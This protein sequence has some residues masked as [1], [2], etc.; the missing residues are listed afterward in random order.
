MS[1]GKVWSLLSL[2]ETSSKKDE[3]KS[4][5][6]CSEELKV[7]TNGAEVHTGCVRRAPGVSSP[8]LSLSARHTPAPPPHTFAT[9]LTLR[10]FCR[11]KCSHHNHTLWD[12]S[13]FKARTFV[14]IRKTVLE[15]VI[16]PK[17]ETC[18]REELKGGFSSWLFYLKT[19]RYEKELSKFNDK[20]SFHTKSL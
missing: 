6:C 18:G 13:A 17:S 19:Q 12:K 9:W 20:A 15:S 3:A 14:V 4:Y 7:K 11:T 1:G 16:E 8:C 2:D 10:S 5:K